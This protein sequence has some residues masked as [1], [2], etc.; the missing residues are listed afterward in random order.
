[1]INSKHLAAAMVLGL[2]IAGWGQTAG[3]VIIG[4]NLT[5]SDSGST[6]PANT[7]DFLLT[8]TSDTAGVFLTGFSFSIGDTTK[9]FDIV[10]KDFTGAGTGVDPDP[11]AGG[12]LTLSGVDNINDGLR[13][14]SFSLAFTSFDPLDLVSWNVDIDDDPATNTPSGAFDSIFFNNGG[15]SNSVLSVTFMTNGMQKTL[16][17]TLPDDLIDK[18][19]Y[20]FTGS[21]NLDPVPEPGTLAL[22]GLGLAG[23]GFARRKR[24]A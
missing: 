22:F 4:Y 8:N 13:A 5:I 12:S 20:T 17:Q 10:R 3:A 16:M 7:Q 18:S 19:S 11:P 15:A 1:M 6:A 2:S 14:D 23:L 9:N 21:M 24:S